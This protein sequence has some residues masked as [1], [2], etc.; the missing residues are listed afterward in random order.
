MIFRK[1]SEI[2]F[3]ILLRTTDFLI[4]G[5]IKLFSMTYLKGIYDASSKRM[6]I[7]YKNKLLENHFD[8]LENCVSEGKFKNNLPKDISLQNLNDGRCVITFSFNL[9]NSDNMKDGQRI[10]SLPKS[11]T[12]KLTDL[13]EEFKGRAIKKEFV[14]TEFIPLSGYSLDKL[15]EDVKDAVKNKRNFCIV[16][17]YSEYLKFAAGDITTLKQGNFAY[18]SNDYSNIALYIYEGNLKKLRETYKDKLSEV[19]WS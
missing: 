8:I 13:L 2:G 10:N 9:P 15:Q 3:K 18:L 7:E 16:D 4:S 14:T 6:I 1:I 11:L 5:T 12:E 19:D 17:K